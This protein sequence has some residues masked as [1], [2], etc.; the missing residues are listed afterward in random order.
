[1]K[2]NSKN[3]L[4]SFILLLVAFFLASFL[5]NSNNNYVSQ[6][7]DFYYTSQ[8]VTFDEFTEYIKN[9][10]I[11]VNL[12]SLLPEGY[13]LTAIYLKKSPFIAIVVYSTDSNKDYKTAELTIQI[14][15]ATQI[16]TC[17]ELVSNIQNGE[18][19]KVYEINNW[20]VLV[21][22]KASSGSEASFIAKYGEYTVLTI[23]WIE[24]IQYVI[25]SPNLTTTNIIT[26]VQEMGP[27]GNQT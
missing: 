5:I 19:E 4:N 18:F 27:I 14:S 10:E 3:L 17:D 21:N 25:N 23:V 13:K 20:P 16:P 11:V 2:K 15:Y 8:Q 12:P 24:E 22:E 9:N 26:L 7:P 1:M 6:P